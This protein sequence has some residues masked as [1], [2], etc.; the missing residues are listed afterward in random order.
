MEIEYVFQYNLQELI[1]SLIRNRCNLHVRQSCHF[2]MFMRWQPLNDGNE[3]NYQKLD[4]LWFDDF[5]GNR[6]PGYSANCL[7]HNYRERVRSAN[8]FG[9]TRHNVTYYHELCCCSLPT[10]I[11][12]TKSNQQ[13]HH[14]P[15]AKIRSRLLV[16]FLI[17]CLL[18]V[19]A[20]SC[21]TCRSQHTLQLTVSHFRILWSSLSE[22]VNNYQKQITFQFIV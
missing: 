8:R 22:K 17:V 13:W 12:L 21:Y 3:K 11:I 10:C 18:S 6:L 1:S 16:S 9:K 20:N 7:L 19:P 5:F 14:W 15:M 2:Q 4:K